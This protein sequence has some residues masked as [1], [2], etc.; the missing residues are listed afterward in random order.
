[1]PKRTDLQSFLI[2]DSG[3]PSH[4]QAAEFNTAD[5]AGVAACGALSSTRASVR[6]FSGGSLLT[7]VGYGVQRLRDGECCCYKDA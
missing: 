7:L 5:C 3:V 6:A 4:R 1:M 2:L